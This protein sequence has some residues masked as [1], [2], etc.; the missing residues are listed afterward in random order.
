MMPLIA[1]R[2]RIPAKPEEVAELVIWLSSAKASF[3]YGS[4]N[5][6]NGGYLFR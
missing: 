3:I 1:A 4:L 2:F 5:P 6:V